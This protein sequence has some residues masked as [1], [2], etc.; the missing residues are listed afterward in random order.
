MRRPAPEVLL[1][2]VLVLVLA[3]AGAGVVL[4]GTRDGAGGPAS[5]PDESASTSDLPTPPP[6]TAPSRSPRPG[7]TSPPES[8]S[9]PALP[10]VTASACPRSV[11]RVPLRVVTINIKSGFGPGGF[12][13]QRIARSIEQWRADVVLLQEVDR[14]RRRSR[15]L[16][17]PQE[18]GRL[19]GMES[20]FG[21]NV[22]GGRR[23][24]YG[25]ATLS[26]YPIVLRSNAH[27]PNLPGL[28]QRGLLRTDLDVD[29]TTVSVFNTHL[30]N[31]PDVT[32]LRVRQL[33]AIRPLVRATEHPA[34]FGG[35]LNS[36]PTSPMLRLAGTFARDVWLDVGTGRGRTAPAG[37][38]RH[39]I[40]Y[41]MYT[42]PL[43]VAR[44]DVLGP[45]ISDHRA[46]AARFV[47]TAAGDE[48]CVPEL[49]G[50]VGSRPGRASRDGGTGRD[51]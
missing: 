40:D 24:L 27:L 50:P 44:A 45:V 23:G 43:Q 18:L 21:L 39:R 3:G 9:P 19:T 6:T 16:D 35:D 22:D 30:Q 51:R 14:F 31:G 17:M 33:A 49:D 34:I 10:S 20:A 7:G 2:V 38:P 28:Q 29:G 13:L 46:V 4:I 12:D 37:S 1:T 32:S 11:E 48:V 36:G 42:A 15:Y 8:A 47:L 25:L 41:L 5:A 26:R